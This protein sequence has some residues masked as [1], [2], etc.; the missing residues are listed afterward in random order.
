MLVI[1]TDD[2][3]CIVCGKYSM[4]F[5]DHSNLVFHIKNHSKMTINYWLD[6]IIC[7]SP[8]D[9]EITLNSIG[10]SKP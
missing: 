8:D 10:Q 7:K 2:S 5:I 6:N 3:C 4:D 9:L 1:L